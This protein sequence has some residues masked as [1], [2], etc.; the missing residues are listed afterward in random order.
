MRDWLGLNRASGAR[1]EKGQLVFVLA[2]SA[3]QQQI[4]LCTDL[5]VNRYAF[6][7]IFLNRPGVR[8][9]PDSKC[10]A[11]CIRPLGPHYTTNTSGSPSV[12]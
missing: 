7:Q 1:P 10:R 6:P 3:S 2:L 8:A 11:Q 5:R 12:E 4:A 9:V